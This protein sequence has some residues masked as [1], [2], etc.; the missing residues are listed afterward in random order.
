[1]SGAFAQRTTVTT[2]FGIFVDPLVLSGTIYNPSA[3]IVDV[4]NPA[5]FAAGHLPGAMHVAYDELIS[6]TDAAPGLLPDAG[7]LKHLLCRL[8]VG[9]DHH[10]IAYDHECGARASRGSPAPIRRTRQ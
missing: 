5:D 1:M 3:L 10:V 6:R 4:T 7:R 9:P 8:G 2:D